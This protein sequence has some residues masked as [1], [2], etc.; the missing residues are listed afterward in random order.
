MPG[1]KTLVIIMGIA[2]IAG[3]TVVVTTIL[4][5]GGVISAPEE[6]GGVI[7]APNANVGAISAPKERGG[8]ISAPKE[9]GAIKLPA[10]ARVVETRLDA[11]RILLRF[12]FAD[13]RQRI[14][15]VD[16][17]TGALIKAHDLVPAA[18]PP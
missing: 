11:G 3:A 6:R 13:G 9:R 4:Q 17:E 7:S 5:R 2:I 12:S 1:L 14:H 15:I 18:G 8:A 16:A 10:G